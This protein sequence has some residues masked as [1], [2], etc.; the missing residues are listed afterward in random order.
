MANIFVKEPIYIT[1]QD[2]KD[3]STKDLTWKTDDELKEII[4]K[5]QKEIDIYIGSYWEKFEET[6]E[7]IF[8]I[9]NT[10]WT[11]YIPNDIT[12]ATVYVSDQLIANWDTIEEHTS[13]GQ[14]TEEK[15]WDRTTKYS[16]TSN[17]IFVKTIPFEAMQILD[18][19]K[20]VFF[21]QIL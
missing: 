21:K 14:I 15:T 3:S 6:Q 4:Y 5:A 9:K 20:K 10:D 13:G 7:F 11:S 2:Y 1:L 16:A 8:P 12:I 19:Y 17:S 18:K